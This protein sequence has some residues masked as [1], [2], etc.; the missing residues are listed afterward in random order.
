MSS[1]ELGNSVKKK[2]QVK[3]NQ[4]HQRND[5]GVGFAFTGTPNPANPNPKIHLTS[6]NALNA[7]PTSL[8]LDHITASS[9]TV[10]I[11]QLEINQNFEGFLTTKESSSWKRHS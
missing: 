11:Q 5:N 8:S 10:T 9:L 2:Q 1:N 4:L 6:E 7:K 3:G